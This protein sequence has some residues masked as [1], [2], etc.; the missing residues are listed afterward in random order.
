MS[1]FTI[2]DATTEDKMIA[3]SQWWQRHC[4][5]F[6]EWY[7]K[8]STNRQ[9][10]LLLTAVPDM[11]EQSAS[12]RSEGQTVK[13]TDLILPEF[14]LEGMLSTQGRLF[15]VFIMRRL[16]SLDRG[17]QEDLKYLNGL[18]VSKRLP[19]F[20]NNSLENMDTPFVD[21]LDVSEN[22]RSLSVTSGSET[23]QT[24]E[25]ML[26]NG[27]LIRA[28]VWLAL[29]I[30]REAI[31]SLFEFLAQE[32]ETAADMKPSPSYKDL[33]QGDQPRRFVHLHVNNHRSDRPMT[34]V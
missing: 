30:R 14:S 33:L 13:P 22:I 11:P 16:T 27:R 25:T 10:E 20:S 1:A 21:P 34:C 2:D 18:L 26:A 17:M 24:I 15:I 23:R 6:S 31:M 28:E 19:S 8:L 12:S 3:L 5:L 7:L 29:R 32:H 4:K 9:R